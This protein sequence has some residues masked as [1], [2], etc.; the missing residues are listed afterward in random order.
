MASTLARTVYRNGVPLLQ[1]LVLLGGGHSHVEVLRIFGQQRKPLLHSASTGH[2]TK[3]RQLETPGEERF[4]QGVWYGTASLSP[5]ASL[6]KFTPGSL[7]GPV[8]GGGKRAR[9]HALCN[10]P[11]SLQPGHLRV[12]TRVLLRHD[13]EVSQC[14]PS[15]SC[16]LHVGDRYIRTES[17]G[18]GGAHVGCH[19]VS[20]RVPP[21][22]SN[23]HHATVTAQVV[24]VS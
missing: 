24:A 20:C 3:Q 5:L 16:P 13:P 23:H 11:R 17:R 12:Q 6:V 9:L 4:A 19:T 2:K 8:K 22:P 21:P 10:G 15:H 1:D 14:K 7:P 18:S